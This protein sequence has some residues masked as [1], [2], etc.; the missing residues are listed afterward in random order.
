MS[1]RGV[2]IAS[3]LKKIYDPQDVFPAGTLMKGEFMERPDYHFFL[4]CS[5]R[6]K[7]EP[8]GICNKKSAINL[9]QYLE[10]ELQDRG[11]DNVLLSSTGCLKLCEQGPVM[12]VYPQNHWYGN[13]NEEVLD[14]ILDALQE[15]KAAEK[16]LLA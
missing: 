10:G 5:F 7:G 12:I 2:L 16:Y 14:E 1:R 15:G 13:L 11:M 4:C 3:V 8:Q 6:V 9:I